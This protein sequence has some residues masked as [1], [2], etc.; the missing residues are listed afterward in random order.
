[1]T[2]P[3]FPSLTALHSTE[4]EG[5]SFHRFSSICE[6]ISLTVITSEVVFL[7][8]CLTGYWK[9]QVVK[10]LLFST[11][12]LPLTKQDSPEGTL[13]VAKGTSTNV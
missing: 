6:S 9:A 7:H 8:C 4:L 12:P 2:P 11:F 1:M 5:F 13:N 10:L 3:G